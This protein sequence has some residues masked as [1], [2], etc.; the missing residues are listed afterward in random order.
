MLFA[1][2]LAAGP[3]LAPMP[4]PVPADLPLSGLKESVYDPNL[5]VLRYPV[6]TRT[7]ECQRSC[8]LGL[9]YFYSY[10]WME[11]ARAFETALLHDPDCAFAWLGLHR[12]LDKWGKG[13]PP[14]DALQAVGGGTL[15]GKPPRD[16]ALDRARQLMDAAPHRE[17]LLIKAKLQERGL[18]KGVSA[19]DRKKEARATLDELLTLHEDD[20]EGWF[21]RAQL[22]E[23]TH[24]PAPFYKALLRV[25]PLHPGA[26]HELVHFFENIKRPA[27]GWQYA[28]G[29]MKSS[30]GVPHALHM[31]AHLATRVGKWTH[32][33]DW[34]RKAVDLQLAYHAAQGVKPADD[35]QYGH[36]LEILTRSLIHDGRF[37]EARQVQA[38]AEK[39]DIRHRPERFRLE[40]GCGDRDAAAKVAD[41]YA[42]T[43][44]PAGAYYRAVLALDSG[45]A[46][47][48]AGHVEV[49]RQAKDRGKAAELRLLEVQ[50]RLLCQTG[51]PDAG[52]KLLKRAVDRTK[53]DFAHHAWGNGASVMEVW[54]VAA[55]EGG[56]PEV[57][58]E[59]FQEALAHDAGS[60]RAAL[61]LWAICDKAGRTEEAG[62]YLELARKCWAKAKP[63][64]F[65]RLQTR[66]AGSPAVA[67]A[68]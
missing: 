25:N 44:K 63:E 61:G 3:E 4:R 58:E 64:D 23:G 21:A 2:L 12:S 27:L 54:G 45:D 6:G 29:Y 65:A 28:E 26:N 40:L 13:A 9:G 51:Q 7:A 42:K 50:G 34:S 18:W 56:R 57:A 16:Y 37:A 19:D 66:L 60:A 5:C 32:T 55:L 35:H 11:A 33:T 47:T 62:R 14:T 43:D 39:A 10:V 17:L 46:A 8:D 68:E 20:E 30:P 24:G 38:V 48:A 41:H 53:D 1:L 36:H 49:L 31:Q 59:A 52:L 22:A 15:K 67:A